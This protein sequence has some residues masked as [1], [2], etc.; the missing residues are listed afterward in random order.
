MEKNM[1]IL[2]ILWIIIYIINIIK[3]LRN[4]INFS[5]KKPFYITYHNLYFILEI[6]ILIL[7]AKYTKYL[8]QTYPILQVN[9]KN[10]VYLPIII[11]LLIVFTYKRN[12]VKDNNKFVLPPDN[13]SKGMN[14]ILI[15]SIICLIT[16]LFITKN[17]YLYGILIINLYFLYNN[18]TFFPCIYNLP[19]TFNK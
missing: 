9:Q 8:F 18:Y 17:K 1:Q 13:I 11:G 5:Y 12:P 15:I 19:N 14:I 6:L 16:S 4:P 3:Y 7:L 10:I 2:W